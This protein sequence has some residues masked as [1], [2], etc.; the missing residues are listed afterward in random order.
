MAQEDK[1]KGDY[2]LKINVEVNKEDD[3]WNADI[4][5]N[6]TG[7]PTF[8][9]GV[10]FSLKITKLINVLGNFP[11][12]DTTQR[13]ITKEILRLKNKKL[14]YNKK[15]DSPGLYKIYIVF[16]PS[17]NPAFG[18]KMDNF[19]K[20]VFE[21]DF[22][23]GGIR[24]RIEQIKRDI[25]DFEDYTRRIN[26]LI[27]ELEKSTGDKK[28]TFLKKAN[29]FS[30]T[31]DNLNSSFFKSKNKGI[32]D[33]S[34]WALG[35]AVGDIEKFIRI[36]KESFTLPEKLPSGNLA[37]WVT[38]LPKFKNK[39]DKYCLREFRDKVGST[40]EVLRREVLL[41][42]LMELDRYYKSPVS[43]SIKSDIREIKSFYR[44]QEM[45]CK[46]S[47]DKLIIEETRDKDGNTERFEFEK[48]FELFDELDKE[49]IDKVRAEY[50][51][52][53]NIFEKKLKMAPSVEKKPEP[54]PLEGTGEED[55][56]KKLKE[57]VDKLIRDA[58]VKDA[59][60]TSLTAK[61]SVVKDNMMIPMPGELYIKKCEGDN[62]KVFS[63]EY[64]DSYD[65]KGNLTRK[66]DKS[67][68]ISGNEIT[69]YYPQKKKAYRYP[70]FG[71]RKFFYETILHSGFSSKLLENFDV[72]K[73]GF[74]GCDEEK[75]KVIYLKITPKDEG[76]KD[77]FA[78]GV[79][80]IIVNPENFLIE[81]IMF[82]IMYLDNTIV[83]I[84]DIREGVDINDE[85][86]D[87]KLDKGVIIE[88]K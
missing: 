14:I 67:A 49:A 85:I 38:Y 41:Y 26:K 43:P 8:P 24:Q 59:T 88:Q 60:R 31:I 73:L 72:V 34:F 53:W 29:D 55:S 33:A 48:M 19:Q 71:K 28:E 44:D 76:L 20:Y 15:L 12:I 57:A 25:K 62:V 4:I 42:L 82:K 18:E 83:K 3:F 35:I 30:T 58:D 84:T 87:L 39:E 47:L 45:K 46:N 63:R 27:D 9:D 66:V 78:N 21:K 37:E 56:A 5:A 32:L 51:K 16:E 22:Y 2:S 77:K 1:G 17:E 7:N 54:K 69:V 23:A 61:L 86:F 52:I 10:A 40:S 68:A 79:I 11:Q 80:D 81:E 74:R 64:L 50:H 36:F 13:E 6:A 70:L 75:N 65:I